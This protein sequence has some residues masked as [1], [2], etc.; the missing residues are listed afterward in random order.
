VGKCSRN[1]NRRSWR[2]SPGGCKRT[3]KGSWFITTAKIGPGW[4]TQCPAVKETPL[5]SRSR[6]SCPD[7]EES[8]CT[9]SS[10]PS[11][12]PS[13]F[14]PTHGP[15]FRALRALSSPKR[16]DSNADPSERCGRERVRPSRVRFMVTEG[17]CARFAAG[18]A[19]DRSAS[20]AMGREPT[21][22]QIADWPVDLGG[23]SDVCRVRASLCP[24]E[25][26]LMSV[27]V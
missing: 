5:R 9:S 7:R 10:L 20:D 24:L 26:G 25:Q 12:L 16:P 8:F 27:G 11:D 6:F 18:P 15:I 13:R 2:H 21:D 14:L 4:A 23:R 17:R 3:A 19:L 1:Y 22:R